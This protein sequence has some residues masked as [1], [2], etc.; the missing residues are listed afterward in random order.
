M[1]MLNIA[2]E[3]EKKHL[4]IFIDIDKV[5]INNEVKEVGKLRT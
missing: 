3:H 1:N 2:S 5:H 4:R